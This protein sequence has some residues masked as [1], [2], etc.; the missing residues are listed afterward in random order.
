MK[1]RPGP[2]QIFVLDRFAGGP[3]SVHDLLH[4]DGVPDHDGMGEHTQA[5]GLVHDFVNV[6]ITELA[7][8][9]KEEPPGEDVAVLSPIQ[10]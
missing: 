2:R 4:V 7:P 10:L 6:A 5:T 9:G 8:I 1:Q 3:Q